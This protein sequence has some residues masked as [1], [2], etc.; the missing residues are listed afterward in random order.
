MG[1]T[2]GALV[3][4]AVGPAI[5]GVITDTLGWEYLFWLNLPLAAVAVILT[6][7][8]TPESKVAGMS[9]TID[10]AG[11]VT[12]ERRVAA[13]L[14][15]LRLFALRAYD[16]ALTANLTM[17]LAFAGLSYLLVLWLQNVR[18]FDAVEAGLLMLPATVGIFAFIPLGGRWQ[19]RSGGRSPVLVGLLVMSAGL[20]ILGFLSGDSG[21]WLMAVALVVI[22]LGLGLLSTPISDT[23]VGQVPAEL[24]G[25]AA[26]VF[27]MSSMVGGALGVAVLAAFARGFVEDDVSAATKAAQMDGDDIDQA[28]RA[29]VNSSSFQDALSSLPAELRQR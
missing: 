15:D 16:A 14:V 29:L 17:N 18:G 11:L 23:T 9:R 28:H 7:V 5:G 24:A 8:A 12:I 26:G 4:A 1:L 10:W 27:K 22:G 20:G 3:I 6:R 13:P 21:L 19:K 2:T 25:A